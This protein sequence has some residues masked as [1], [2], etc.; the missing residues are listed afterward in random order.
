MGEQIVEDEKHVIFDCDLYANIRSKFIST[1]NNSRHTKGISKITINHS[2]L[3]T[4][5]MHLLSPNS[6]PEI[7][8]S[9][10]DQFNQHH[11]NLNLEPNTAA[12]T[13]LLE[14]RSHIINTVCSLIYR[15]LDKRWKYFKDFRKSDLCNLKT[16]VI[17]ITR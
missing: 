10:I 16:I 13:S 3:K 1:L 7:S 14:A 11:T 6:V 2:S 5:L 9:I 4:N 15:C 8:P 12:Y 17:A